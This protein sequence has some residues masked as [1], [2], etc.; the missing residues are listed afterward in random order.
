MGETPDLTAVQKTIVDTFNEEGICRTSLLK[1]LS[2]FMVLNR[3]EI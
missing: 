2:V 3:K 1:K